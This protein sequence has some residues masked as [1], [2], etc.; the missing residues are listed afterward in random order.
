M[1]YFLF[2]LFFSQQKKSFHPQNEMRF[3]AKQQR[4]NV[5]QKRIIKMCWMVLT[6]L[7]L[8]YPSLLIFFCNFFA[9]I[10]LYASLFIKSFWSDRS[11][12]I[13]YF[14]TFFHFF[15]VNFIYLHSNFFN[16]FLFLF[17]FTDY[18]FL[19]LLFCI[20]FFFLLQGTQKK[21][22]MLIIMKQST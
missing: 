14:F 7:A 8:L 18:K 6:L 2:N 15:V 9:I 13:F 22:I 11:Y 3:N 17:F 1:P 19:F 4:K 10:F 5:Q 12:P 21:I 20:I 16:F